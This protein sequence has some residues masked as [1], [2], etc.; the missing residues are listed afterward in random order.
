MFENVEQENSRRHSEGG[1]HLK[2]ILNLGLGTLSLSCSQTENGFSC[3]VNSMKPSFTCSSDCGA[4]RKSSHTDRLL[5]CASDVMPANSRKPTQH[6]FL[7]GLPITSQ[8]ITSDQG[9]KGAT[10][11]PETKLQQRVIST[12][13]GVLSSRSHAQG[14]KGAVQAQASP[15]THPASAAARC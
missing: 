13:L 4:A 2:M 12:V 9:T 5:T 3:E 15:G 11:Q 10:S 7:Y 6:C 1:A 14:P 8:C